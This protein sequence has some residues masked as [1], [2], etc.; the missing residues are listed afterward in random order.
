MFL[1]ATPVSCY[2]F[3]VITFF[4]CI[5]VQVDDDDNFDEDDL[6]RLAQA[7]DEVSAQ[8]AA[9]YSSALRCST[10]DERYHDVQNACLRNS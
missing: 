8:L 10:T 5:G 6:D 9:A 2:P 3:T 4:P 1:P 7:A